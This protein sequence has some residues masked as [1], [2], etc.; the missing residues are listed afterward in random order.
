MKPPPTPDQRLTG[1]LA[2][3]IQNF[4]IKTGQMKQNQCTKNQS[5]SHWRKKKKQQFS[6]AP[7]PLG[8][9]V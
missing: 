8:G 4:F 5:S 1:R 3:F 9:V 7:P 2:F 6:K